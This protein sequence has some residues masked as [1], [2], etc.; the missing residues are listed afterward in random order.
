MP[1]KNVINALKKYNN[2]LITTHVNPEP[3]ALGS[4]L[5]I[6]ELLKKLKKKAAIINSESLPEH[7][8]FLEGINVIKHRFP[9][10]ARFD[11]AIVVDCPN[12]SRTGRLKDHLK[13][14]RFIINI[15]HH[16]SNEK[17][18]D[19]NWVKP[20]ASSAAEMVYRLYEKTKEDISKKVALYIYI[21][22]LTDTGSFNYSNTS[23]V[24]HEIVSE[25]LGYGL[26][27]Q[28]ISK[29]LYENKRY[30]DLKLLGHVLS[31]LTLAQ[32][33]KIAYL[34][35]TNN[36]REKAGSSVTATENFVNFARS[37]GGVDIAFFIREEEGRRNYFK[38]SL[39]SKSNISVNK[40]AA[41][42][43]GGGHKYAAGCVIKG[44]LTDVKKKVLS[45]ACKALKKR[46]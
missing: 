14:I 3:D 44:T 6:Y 28:A 32:N 36:M 22:I 37:I 42:F 45:Q 27:P 19:V 10:N 21:A 1:I 38:I 29:S 30:G 8:Q 46:G 35:C 26:Y 25:L 43:G 31:T 41:T 4:E 5:A 7:Y 24:T 40:I 33:G 15:D 20:D 2:F 23:S 17:F 12:T 34:T 18:G 13:K 16:I 11:A 39:R 9:R